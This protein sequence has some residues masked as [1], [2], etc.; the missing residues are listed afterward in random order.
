MAAAKS[1]GTTAAL[2]ARLRT[3]VA[4]GG[5]GGRGVDPEE[6]VERVGSLD[7]RID[8]LEAQLEAL[9]DSVH[10]ESARQEA[11]I[12]ALERKTDPEALTRA[13]A[14]DARRRRI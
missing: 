8:R 4:G 12:Q 9:Q 6:V 5:R 1:S 7:A 2:L 11:L 13:L 10:R 3:R 14:E